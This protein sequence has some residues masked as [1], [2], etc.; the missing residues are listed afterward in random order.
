MLTRCLIYT[1]NRLRDSHDLS[2][3][4]QIIDAISRISGAKPQNASAVYAVLTERAISSISIDGDNI[5]PTT[6]T[7]ADVIQIGDLV[8]VNHYSNDEKQ[9]ISSVAIVEDGKRV[10]EGPNG[11]M[12]KL[13]FWP[14]NPMDAEGRVI[15]LY[16]DSDFT[17][18]KNKDSHDAELFRQ[19]VNS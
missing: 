3:G 6:I 12:Y 5:T 14:L 9:V 13:R 4:V 15:D 10:D 8:T 1:D 7:V 16:S 19:L 11:M 17:F 18:Y 2:D